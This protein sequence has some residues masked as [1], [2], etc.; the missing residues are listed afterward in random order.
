MSIHTHKNVQRPG[1][2]C[3]TLKIRQAL[4]Q[5]L[6]FKSFYTPPVSEH[7]TTLELQYMTAAHWYTLPIFVLPLDRSK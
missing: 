6:S 7:C 2:K 5:V 1:D 3:G 4:K